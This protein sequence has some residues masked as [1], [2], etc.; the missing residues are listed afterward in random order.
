MGSTEI[1]R[2]ESRI[3]APW[4][5]SRVARWSV[6]DGKTTVLSGVLSWFASEAS[7]VSLVWNWNA[8]VPRLE[9][10]TNPRKLDT[11][12]TPVTV[13]S[14]LAVL[15]KQ[16]TLKAPDDSVTSIVP[17][18]TMASMT[19]MVASMAS[20][21]APMVSTEMVASM[22][23]KEA[24]LAS[25]ALKAMMA[26][27]S[28]AWVVLM[29]WVTD[30]NWRKLRNEILKFSP[31]KTWTCSST[32]QAWDAEGSRSSRLADVAKVKKELMGSQIWSVVV[33]WTMMASMAS[34]VVGG[35]EW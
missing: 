12:E 16:L 20:M 18:A 28:L 11:K 1:G 21:V 34:M 5:G 13:V 23:S 32:K 25:V 27:A 26:L 35:D 2:L 4:C 29:G 30:L 3:T 8:M 10:A 7:L 15:L 14:A 9:I 6:V 33:T 19:S 22:D 17:M 31:L 24:S